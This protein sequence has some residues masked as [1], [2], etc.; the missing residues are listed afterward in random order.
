MDKVIERDV[1][2]DGIDRAHLDVDEAERQCQLADRILRNVGRDA[3]NTGALLGSHVAGCSS[4]G[5]NVVADP[6]RGA[7]V[8]DQDFA[9]G[10]DY[11][12][13]RFEVAMNHIPRVRKRHRFADPQKHA[14][15]Q[16]P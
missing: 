15:P 10:S 9:E 6:P 7:P 5:G 14:Q 3:G 4:S 13:L 12:V 1:A 2:G 11:D 8:E 16:K